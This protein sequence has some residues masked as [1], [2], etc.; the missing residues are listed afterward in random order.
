MGRFFWIDLDVSRN[1]KMP[2]DQSLSDAPD[3]SGS[4]EKSRDRKE[5]RHDGAGSQDD[6]NERWSH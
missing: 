2:I 6:E 3:N 5:A 1:A 4:F